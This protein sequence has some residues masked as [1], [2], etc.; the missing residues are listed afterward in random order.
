MKNKFIMLAACVVLASV[1]MIGCGKDADSASS[2]AVETEQDTSDITIEDAVKEGNHD[3]SKKD[4]EYT[5]IA[6][7]V[8]SADKGSLDTI[9]GL[10]NVEVGGEIVKN[11]TY[12]FSENTMSIVATLI[13]NSIV[14][15]LGG[16][17]VT[18]TVFNIRGMGK[19]ALT[20]LQ[21]RDYPQE[22][23]IVLLMA[24]IFLGETLLMDILYKVLDPRIEYE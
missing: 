11:T 5:A 10:Y 15:M 1:S 12:E 23:A 14:S 24:F 19:L 2:T 16:A 6:E 22:Q 4:N 20:S 7:A 21:R 18:E 8:S 9:S 3:T 17:T 13:A